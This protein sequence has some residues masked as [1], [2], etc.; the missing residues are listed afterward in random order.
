MFNIKIW[1]IE[2]DMKIDIKNTLTLIRAGVYFLH[3][4]C[5]IHS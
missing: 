3:T 1:L 5:N 4:Y 2:I